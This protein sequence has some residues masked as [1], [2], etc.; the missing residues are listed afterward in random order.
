MAHKA[1][2]RFG[3]NFLQ[4]HN[5]ISNIL[6]HIQLDENQ[7]WV[8]IGPG[9]GALTEPLLQEKVKLDIIE[10]DRDL[11]A[12]LSE[13]FK[14][15]DNLTIHSADALNF[16]FSTLTS[17]D[18]KLRIIGN[19]PYNISTPLMF[20]LLDSSA[21]IEDMH[22]M[23]QK[24]VVDR[25]CAEP[26]SKKYGR[27]SVMMQ[28]FCETEFLFEVP[29]ES[30]DPAPKV[31]SA[32]V[33]LQPYT[34]PIVSVYN[35]KTLND[36]VTQAFSQRRKTIRNSLGKLISEAQI[37]ALGIDP[38]LRAESLTLTEFAELSNLVVQQSMS[39]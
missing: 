9:L 35:F 2:K 7:H 1:R 8:E 12:Y 5:I 30:F 26:G 24:E 10:L 11:V 39:L 19:L 29:P 28:Y 38:N 17:N 20:H 15:Y 22:F 27:L 16:D 21:Q 32:I 25:I 6:S 4:D 13:K 23:L 31:M 34:K 37:A 33:R 36:V 18:E 3:Q 14:N